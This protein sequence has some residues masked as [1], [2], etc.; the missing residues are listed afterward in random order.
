MDTD[1]EVEACGYVEVEPCSYVDPVAALVARAVDSVVASRRPS[2]RKRRHIEGLENGET[3]WWRAAR[4]CK[5]KEETFTVE[6]NWRRET[7][8]QYLSAGVGAST[9]SSTTTLFIRDNGSDDELT[10]I[11]LRMLFAS[12][13]EASQ[14]SCTHRMAAQ[15]VVDE[16][17]RHV[18]AI[19]ME[20]A[21]DQSVRLEM[22]DHRVVACEALVTMDASHPILRALQA[23]GCLRMLVRVKPDGSGPLDRMCGCC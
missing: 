19:T 3:P 9:R 1:M 17:L 8:A 6:F 2:A 22:T 16:P 18:Y 12:E 13:G 5:R 4:G 14:Q 23:Q 11:E 20:C 10:P 7:V 21:F 15:I